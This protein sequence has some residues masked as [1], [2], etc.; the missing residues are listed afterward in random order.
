M[1]N[2]FSNNETFTPF[3]HGARGDTF[4]SQFILYPLRATSATRGTLCA[5]PRLESL[6]RTI[7]RLFLVAGEIEG[8]CCEKNI[9]T[10]YV[11]FRILIM[12]FINR[13]VFRLLNN[14]S[15][16]FFVSFSGIRKCKCNLKCFPQQT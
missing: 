8:V 11:N 15:F 7:R 5:M 13:S 3:T 6:I 2:R 12:E 4:L 16:T 14:D 9:W 10:I 1:K